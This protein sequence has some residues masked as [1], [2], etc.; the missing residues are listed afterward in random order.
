MTGGSVHLMVCLVGVLVIW[1]VSSGEVRA[2]VIMLGG[3]EHIK[4]FHRTSTRPSA[5]T[6]VCWLMRG[7]RAHAALFFFF[8]WSPALSSLSE[9]SRPR[10][11]DAAFGAEEG[12]SMATA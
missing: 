12:Q 6:L 7:W 5:P 10:S 1:V 9:L 4:Y 3:F 11:I 8:A 2:P